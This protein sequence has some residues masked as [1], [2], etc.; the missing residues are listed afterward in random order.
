MN[1]TQQRAPHWRKSSFSG[2]QGG[3]CVEIA[4]VPRAKLIRDSKRPDGAVLRFSR[5]EW[6]SFLASVRSGDV[7]G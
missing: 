1:D 6:A 5:S 4:D 3:Q 7:R 2:A